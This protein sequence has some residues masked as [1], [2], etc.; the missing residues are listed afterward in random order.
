MLKINYNTYIYVFLTFFIGSKIVKDL[1]EWLITVILCQFSAAIQLGNKCF[2][3]G[4]FSLVSFYF[5]IVS[6]CLNEIVELEKQIREII[7]D[8]TFLRKI[9][10]NPEKTK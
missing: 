6:F 4:F 3:L 5:F 2:V 1:R 7:E 9:G 10:N 8:N